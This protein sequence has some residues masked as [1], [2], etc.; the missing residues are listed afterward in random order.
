[1]A[2][3]AAGVAEAGDGVPGT[4]NQ[5]TTGYTIPYEGFLMLDNA[6]MTGLQRLR[7]ELWGDASS[8]ASSQLLYAETQDVNL[9][10]GQ[11]TLS[12]GTGTRVSGT[13]VEAA[14]KDGDKLYLALQVEDGSNTFIPL[15]GRQA[16]E[17][18]PFSAWTA[19]ASD[20]TVAGDLTVLGNAV[21]TSGSIGAS[22]I[23]TNAVG[24]S[25]IAANA[26]GASEIASNAVGTAEV[27]NNSL[28]ANDIA[29]NAIG[30]SELN[31]PSLFT[32]IEESVD[33]NA[34][35]YVTVSSSSTNGV[36]V[37]SDTI[38]VPTSGSIFASATCSYRCYNC[39]SRLVEGY[40]GITTSGSASPFN[41]TAVRMHDIFES[42]RTHTWSPLAVQ[43][44]LSVSA[45]THSIFVRGRV[46]ATSGS[47]SSTPG[48]EIRCHLA[49]LFIPN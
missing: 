36:T 47:G 39:V 5:F 28:T 30:P 25:E 31:V 27:A 19:N 42:N 17:P 41:T 15:S 45:G 8:T 35:R 16:I 18:V 32:A 14:V 22:E 9:Y 11:F 13:T 4:S 3:A 29:A 2:L 48:M 1:M 40:M 7:I 26:V 23:A 33:A 37:A 43:D 49:T 46:A 6:P 12:V 21:L 20:M 34:S 24:A 38:T 44:V 10:S